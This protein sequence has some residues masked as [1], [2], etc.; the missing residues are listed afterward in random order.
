[1][2][3]LAFATMTA[4]AALL[5]VWP[6][7]RGAAGTEP[8]AADLAFYKSQLAEVEGDLGREAV[9]PAEAAAT[10]AEIARRLLA[11]AGAA[12]A[13]PA[14]PSRG[15]RL[16]AVLLAVGAVPAGSLA[17]YLRLGHPGEPDAP[18]AARQDPMAPGVDLAAALPRIEAHLAGH[19]EDGRGFALVAPL[20]MRL[21]RYD[22]AAKAYAAALRDSGEDA[23]RRAALGQALVMAAAGVVTSEA[24]AAFD[25]ALADDP[26]LPEARFF[27]AVAAEQDGDK[28]RAARLWRE[29]LADTPPDAPWRAGVQARLAALSGP[30]ALPARPSRGCRP[31]SSSRPSAAWWRGSRA[32]LRRMVATPVAGCG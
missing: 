6:L 9:A 29:L 32:A 14:R 21:G 7:A 2:I 24:R 16:L 18:L 10:R 1:M 11:A 4:A 17:L 20:Y 12:P 13:R 25:Q 3:W 27:T 28:P 26:K 5:L 30:A 15:A 31:T 22:D 23:P 8:E 19:P